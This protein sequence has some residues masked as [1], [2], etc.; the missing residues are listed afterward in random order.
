M[1]FFLLFCLVDSSILNN[2]N[3]NVKLNSPQPHINNKNTMLSN[4]VGGLS[5]TAG[6]QQ[7]QSFMDNLKIQQ[8]Q[9]QPHN[10]MYSPTGNN[11]NLNYEVAS[12]LPKNQQGQMQNE[13]VYLKKHKSR[14]TTSPSPNRYDL[15]L[16]STSSEK[17]KM[18]R[19]TRQ[20][21]YDGFQDPQ[22]A[23]NRQSKSSQSTKR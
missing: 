16:K 17:N 1:I 19:S 15:G 4:F 21:K 13:Q 14:S 2:S 7:Q 6:F 11:A 22:F 5:S 18:I 20:N 12:Y 8:Q 3:N 23:R 9:T 10:R